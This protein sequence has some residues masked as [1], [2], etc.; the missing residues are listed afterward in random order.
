MAKKAGFMSQ[1]RRMGHDALRGEVMADKTK[2][3]Y[4]ANFEKYV[5]WARTQDMERVRT[6]EDLRDP[7]RIQRWVDHLIHEGKSAWTVRAYA[8]AAIRITGIQNCQ[9]DSSG[10]R[11]RDEKGKVIPTLIALPDRKAENIIK[12]KPQSIDK[13]ATRDASPETWDFN[14]VVGLRRE[15]LA[16][17]KRENM[18]QDESGRWCVEVV[19]GKGGKPQLQR[20]PDGMEKYIAKFFV[21]VQRGERIF[22]REQMDN[23][24]D[25]HAHRRAATQRMYFSCIERMAADPSY[26]E[27][28]INDIKA[29]VNKENQK[30]IEANKAVRSGMVAK[31][32]K[33]SGNRPLIK[34]QHVLRNIDTPIVRRGAAA[35]R[36]AAEGLP[37]VLD[38]LAA[39]YVGIF[40]LSH[41]DERTALTHYLGRK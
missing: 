18:V 15:E 5:N 21:R 19:N 14:Q 30:R 38:R 22:T 20:I 34:I 23:K 7:S 1:A 37:V 8:A 13:R 4:K 31:K 28:M 6:L 41:W 27:R 36:A 33:R 11:L 40:T 29:R 10:R 39:V 32:G 24:I 9:Y 2:N 3:A 26:R 25:Y 35:E 16:E 12:G 17:L